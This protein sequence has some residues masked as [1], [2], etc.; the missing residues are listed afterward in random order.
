MTND[1]FRASLL[2]AE[3]GQLLSRLASLGMSMPA[4]LDESAKVSAYL[5]GLSSSELHSFKRDLEHIIRTMTTSG[6]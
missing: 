6:G 5:E 3:C 1:L 2:R 4:E